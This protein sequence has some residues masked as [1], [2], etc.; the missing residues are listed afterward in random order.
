MIRALKLLAVSR[1]IWLFEDKFGRYGKNLCNLGEKENFHSLIHLIIKLEIEFRGRCR[2]YAN[3]FGAKIKDSMSFREMI[4]MENFSIFM[5][6]NNVSASS[7]QL[8]LISFLE[9]QTVMTSFDYHEQR[10]LHP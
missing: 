2:I 8:E 9:K 3:T 7:S 6:T 5:R 4:S 10:L 1:I